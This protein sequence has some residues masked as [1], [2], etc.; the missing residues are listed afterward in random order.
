MR[1]AG[2]TLVELL[3]VIG[4]VAVLIAIL[5]PALAVARTQARATQ[6]LSNLRQLGI[7]AHRYVADNQ[8][9][10]PPAVIDFG[11]WD[12]QTLSTGQVVPGTLWDNNT[13]ALAVQQCPEY[14]LH[15]QSAGTDPYT[16]Y[17]YNVSFVGHGLGEADPTPAKLSSIA[18]S[19]RAAMFGDGQYA[20]GTDK[21]MR[22]PL[23]EV[24]LTTGDSVGDAVRLAGTQGYRHRGKTN[25]CYCDGHAAAVSD[26]FTAVG[27]I[28]AGVAT[29]D[30]GFTAAAGTGFLSADDSAYGAP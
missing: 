27:T 23:L 14:V 9:L 11:A 10:C 6:C 21:F 13:T 26:V 18:R 16:G 8:G 4:I 7:E 25:V 30:A 5:L 1:R 17:N 2:F 15:P 29:Y 28:A 3:V 19:E 24:P 12:Y 20:A 22:A